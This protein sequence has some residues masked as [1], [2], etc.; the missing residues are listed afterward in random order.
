MIEDS[1]QHGLMTI[2]AADTSTSI[3]SVAVCRGGQLVAEVVVE[4]RRL[5]SE[6]LIGVVD[7]LLAEAG[8]SL[9]QIEV[10]AV[11]H[12]PGSFTG[13]RIGV[14]TWKGLAFGLKR[15]L[16]GVPTLDALSR[17]GVFENAVVCAVLDARMHEVFAAA[18]L[19]E[20]GRRTKIVPDAVCP[21]EVFLG[22]PQ[23][24]GRPLVFLGDGARNYEDRIRARCPQAVF[25][26]SHC[27]VPRAAAVAAEALDLLEQGG[28]SEAALVSPIYLRQSQAEQDRERALAGASPL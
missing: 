17:A 26:A 8:L 18:Y 24:Q 22:Q 12:G 25:A 28:P 5:H 19:F 9:D 20:Q 14:A 10:L 4:S 21:I 11:S 2:L 16:V 13:L 15:P 27:A 23:L 1:S 6:R 7:W 3:N